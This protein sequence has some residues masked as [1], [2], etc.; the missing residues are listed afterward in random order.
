M[1]PNPTEVK[2]KRGTGMKTSCKYYFMTVKEFQ[3][4]FKLDPKLKKEVIVEIMD[5]GNIGTQ[6]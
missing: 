6:S 3:R 4:H 1:F 5:E 2:T